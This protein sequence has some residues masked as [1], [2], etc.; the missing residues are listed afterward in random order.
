MFKKEKVLIKKFQ[1]SILA[2]S[3]IILLAMFAIV[4]SITYVT[5]TNKKNVS[6]SQSSAQALQVA[7]SGAQIETKNIISGMQINQSI[8]DFYKS[9]CSTINGIATVSANLDPINNSMPYT[10]EFYDDAAGT[11]KIASCN[12]NLSSVQNIK[13]SGSFKDTSRAISVAVAASSSI[14]GLETKTNSISVPPASGGTV[15]ATC[16][17]G[18]KVLGGGCKITNPGCGGNFCST[19]QSS[20]P[21]SDSEWT[22]SMTHPNVASTT[23]TAYV[24][25]AQ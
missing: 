18:K 15:V 20:Y 11:S 25:C 3:L 6:T 22:C 8:K 5:I 16:S 12:A 9:A 1:G 4:V 2:Y 13:V 14:N 23:F 10:V 17:A 24:I 7:D 21:S 19:L